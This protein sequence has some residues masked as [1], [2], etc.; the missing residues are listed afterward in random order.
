DLL[1]LER[2]SIIEIARSIAA[3]TGRMAAGASAAGDRWFAAAYLTGPT[4]GTEADDEQLGGTVRVAAQ[5]LKGDDYILHVGASA[6]AVFQPNQNGAGVVGV[7]RQTIQLRDRPEL[8]LDSTRFLDTGLISYDD[9]YVGGLELAGHYRNFSL[10]GEYLRINVDQ[11]RAAG[12]VSPNLNFDGFYVQ[13]SWIITGESR[14]YNTSSAAYAAP[15]V[16]RPFRLGEGGWGAWE[17]VARYSYV[18]LNDEDAPGQPV[19][20]TGGVRGGEQATYTVGLNW[21]PNQN[22]RFMLDYLY[23]DIDRQDAAGTTQ[24]GQSFQALALRSQWSF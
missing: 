14:R 20:Q 21:Y 22:V 15:R 4:V 19:A 11:D 24:I 3:G 5:P 13:G 1:F 10:Q 18:D 23:G 9:A 12:L 6:A 7:N 16:A 2:P 8:R 17:V